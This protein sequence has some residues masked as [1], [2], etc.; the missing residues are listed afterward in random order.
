MPEDTPQRSPR[1]SRWKA[2]RRLT[3][4]TYTPR[5]QDPYNAKEHSRRC[6]EAYTP[7][8]RKTLAKNA[9][10]RFSRRCR[11]TWPD[12]TS[13]EYPSARA[14]SEALGRAYANVLAKLNGRQPQPKAYRVEW[15]EP[16][17][18]QPADSQSLRN[19]YEVTWPDG[20]V[21]RHENM[22]AAA[23]ALGV[24]YQ[25]MM[26]W[27]H[28]ARPWPGKGQRLSAKY[29]HL[30]GITGRVT[31]DPRLRWPV[32]VQWPP[33]EDDPNPVGRYK[34]LEDAAERLMVSPADIITWIEGIRPATRPSALYGAAFS[35]GPRPDNE[36]S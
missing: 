21:D 12:G 5:L 9:S 8:R 18:R 34:S 31:S 27:T 14:L 29:A 30:A 2:Q 17:Q 1:P 7:E 15:I 22:T 3:F 28:G 16:P 13:Q 6:K 20:R 32:V 25:T 10:Q 33:R 26:A 24:P 36:K 19:V 35:W 4:E 11:V 23:V